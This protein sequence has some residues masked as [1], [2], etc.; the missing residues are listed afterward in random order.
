MRQ[1]TQPENRCSSSSQKHLSQLLAWSLIVPAQLGGAA[2][3]VNGGAAG[4]VT[5]EVVLGKVTLMAD[6][7]RQSVAATP[8]SQ[9]LAFPIRKG[10][11]CAIWVDGEET[12][13]YSAVGEP[14]FSPDGKRLAYAAY[15]DGRWFVVENGQEGPSGEGVTRPVFSPDSQQLAYGIQRDNKFHMMR[16][17]QEGPA[18]DTIMQPTVFSPDSKHFAYGATRKG[19][20]L[21]VFDSKE[22]REYES[23]GGNSLQ[24]FSPNSHR[25]AY[26]GK[27]GKQYV[28]IVDGKEGPPYEL[29]ASLKYEFSPDSQHFSYAAQAGGRHR[30]VLDGEELRVPDAEPE[31]AARFSPDGQRMAL[32][33]S[34]G[35]NWYIWA[36]QKLSKAY[37]QIGSEVVFS[38]NSRRLAYVA[39]TGGHW[40][41]VDN[42]KMEG[43]NYDG[44]SNG[45]LEFSPDS[46]HLACV[47]L[48]GTKWRLVVDGVE[49][50]EY[51]AVMGRDPSVLVEDDSSTTRR[52]PVWGQPPVY[53]SPDSRHVVYRATRRNQ[54]LVVV[55]NNE[56][57]PYARILSYPLFANDRLLRFLATRFNDRLEEEIVRVE[58]EL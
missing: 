56:S 7:A 51:D 14:L 44:I 19:K 41:I 39:V 31:D 11:R 34:R 4:L 10:S 57:R 40:Q 53:F 8:D 1:R 18:F 33:V 36:D 35:S 9:R 52:A 42:G 30:L 22:E 25:Y 38:P 26:A 47:V 15:R 49:G 29:I 27:R 48:C 50:S 17:G 24:F 23:I 54:R 46:Q 5:R 21:M 2:T 20:R 58:L 32:P 37:D 13:T 6:L 12:G 16:G 28:M 55:D 3:N 45:P 43:K